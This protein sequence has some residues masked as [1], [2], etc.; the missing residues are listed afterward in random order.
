MV[1]LDVGVFLGTG[2]FDPDV[3]DAGVAGS[4]DVAFHA[5]ANHDGLFGGDAQVGEEALEDFRLRFSDV[6]FARDDDGVEKIDESACGDLLALEIGGTIGEE[7]DPIIEGKA[8]EDFAGVGH[9]ANELSAF[10]FESR[11]ELLGDVVAFELLVPEG[12][13]EHVASKLVGPIVKG[14]E[15]V[16]DA[17][18]FAPQALIRGDPDAFAEG[19]DGSGF[20]QAMS[21]FDDGSLERGFVGAEG[22]KGEG[23]N[24]GDGFA[25]DGFIDDEGVVE[26][27][28]N[29]ADRHGASEK[30]EAAGEFENFSRAADE[31]LVGRWERGG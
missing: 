1:G 7:S 28:K 17:D 2:D 31:V 23:C 25:G 3:P 30:P 10:R 15:V 26:I 24:D 4:G 8:G 18:E 14:L 16:G 12:G 9:E 21:V 22:G 29:G 20:G 6:V 13:V 19:A 11:R 5:V 27:E